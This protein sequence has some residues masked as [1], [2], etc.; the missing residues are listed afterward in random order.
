MLTYEQIHKTFSKLFLKTVQTGKTKKFRK[1]NEIHAGNRIAY[2]IKRSKLTV[3][4]LLMQNEN[5]LDG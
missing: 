5:A 4:H 1:E 2:F 3:F